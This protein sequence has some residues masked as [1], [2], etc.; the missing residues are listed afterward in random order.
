MIDAIVTENRIKTHFNKLSQKEK[1]VAGKQEATK[2]KT[3]T[4]I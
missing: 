3:T 1:K 2:T 4:K